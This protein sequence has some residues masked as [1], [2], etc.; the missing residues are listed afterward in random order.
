MLAI[1][2]N[3]WPIYNLSDYPATQQLMEMVT[4]TTK[5]DYYL[6]THMYCGLSDSRMKQ[7]E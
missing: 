6:Y 3:C 1:L 4:K 5:N 2:F 7:R